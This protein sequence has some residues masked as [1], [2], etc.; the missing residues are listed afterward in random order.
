MSSPRNYYLF[1][2]RTS[3]SFNSSALNVSHIDSSPVSGY[4]GF[5]WYFPIIGIV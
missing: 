4:Y 1:K 3:K 2:K 5:V